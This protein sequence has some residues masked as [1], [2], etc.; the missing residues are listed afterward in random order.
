MDHKSSVPASTLAVESTPKR[1]RWDTTPLV[2]H[3]LNADIALRKVQA[4]PIRIDQTPSRFSETPLRRGEQQTPRRW[5][6]KTPLI[7]GATP[8]YAGMTPTPN[9]LKTPDILNMTPS[10][11]VQ[12]RREQ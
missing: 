8:S 4:T 12:L 3:D 9:N 6:D 1:T 2:K 11:L 5:D 10:K 7:G